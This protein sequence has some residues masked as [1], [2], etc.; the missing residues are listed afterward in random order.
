LKLAFISVFVIPDTLL[1]DVRD[2]V[3]P[4]SSLSSLYLMYTECPVT[5]CQH[6]DISELYTAS[7]GLSRVMVGREVTDNPKPQ[8]IQKQSK[9]DTKCI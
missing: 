8:L 9:Q 5:L 3:R 4:T 2:A 1:T 6:L 7:S